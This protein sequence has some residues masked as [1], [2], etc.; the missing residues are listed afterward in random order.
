MNL[1]GFF[2]FPLLSSPVREGSGRK[3]MKCFG[4][5]ESGTKSDEGNLEK[6]GWM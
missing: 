1:V 4:N 2:S 3:F 6:S 5:P